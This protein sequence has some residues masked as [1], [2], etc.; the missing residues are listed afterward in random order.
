MISLLAALGLITA[1]PIVMPDSLAL[2]APQGLSTPET[3]DPPV[4]ERMA[5]GTEFDP[6]GG[7]CFDVDMAQYH[8]V[9]EELDAALDEAGFELSN[10]H[11][12]VVSSYTRRD[13][14]P[15]CEQ[16]LLVLLAPPGDGPLRAPSQPDLR[17]FDGE[18][19]LLFAPIFSEGCELSRR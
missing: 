8:I 2:P 11:M 15:G 6:L 19:V 4:L 18:G 14:P 7:Y 12:L 1:Q 13:P 3:C 10:R 17:P 5:A 9:L 16:S